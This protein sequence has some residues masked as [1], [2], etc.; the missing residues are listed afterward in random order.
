MKTYIKKIEAERYYK[1]VKAQTYKPY[2]LQIQKEK[3][4]LV[5]IKPEP[6]PFT[7]NR[8]PFTEK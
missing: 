7:F 6:N 1:K 5:L 4:Y 2:S 8:E 3:H